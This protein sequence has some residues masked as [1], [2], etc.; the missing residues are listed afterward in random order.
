MTES[1]IIDEI[2]KRYA[3]KTGKRLSREQARVAQVQD[4]AKVVKE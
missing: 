1:E 2:R 3:R 4:D